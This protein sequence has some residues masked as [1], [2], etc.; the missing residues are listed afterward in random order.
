MLEE[1]ST[2][3]RI[4]EAVLVVD[5]SFIY[6]ILQFCCRSVAVLQA[7]KCPFKLSP[8]VYMNIAVSSDLSPDVLIFIGKM[9]YA[10]VFQFAYM[11]STL[12]I[13]VETVVLI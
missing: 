12:V 8:H 6:I 2:G 13:A 11:C 4:P 7:W 1:S 9:A 10:L 5:A 3:C